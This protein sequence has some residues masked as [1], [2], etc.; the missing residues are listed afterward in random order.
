ML[1]D[2]PISSSSVCSFKF[3]LKSSSHELLIFSKLLLFHASSIQIFPSAACSQTPF[4][5]SLRLSYTPIQNDRQIYIL[6]ILIFMVF[7]GSNIWPYC[8]LL[9]EQQVSIAE[10]EKQVFIDKASQS[11]ASVQ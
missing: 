5:L 3:Y 4:P 7:G 11:F 1:H 2:L 9:L 10:P 8:C 6:Y